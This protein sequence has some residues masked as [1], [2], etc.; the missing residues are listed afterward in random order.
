MTAEVPFFYIYGEPPREVDSRFVHVERVSDR[1]AVH[2]G[3]VSAHSHPHLHQ[4]SF[5]REAEGDYLIESERMTLPGTAL[6]VMPAGIVHGFDVPVRGDAIVISMSE[7]FWADC[8]E[9]MDA[10]IVDALAGPR[11]LDVDE[12]AEEFGLLFERVE[13]E[14]RYPSWAQADAMAAYVRLI[15]ILIARLGEAR[16]KAGSGVNAQGKRLLTRFHILLERHFRERWSVE[17]YV[18][19]LGTTAY[20]LNNA[21]RGGH[22]LSAAALVRGRTITE[23]KRLLLY[24]ALQIFEISTTLG[25][26]DQTHFSRAFR[27]AVGQSPATWRAVHLAARR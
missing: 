23:A 19:E 12:M 5:W 17:R 16:N 9:A 24:T 20:L 13:R 26:E 22:D 1:V 25:F 4:L 2:N 6:V 27:Q 7:G 21:A 3:H 10:R 8:T 18:E 15:L 11:L 14:Y